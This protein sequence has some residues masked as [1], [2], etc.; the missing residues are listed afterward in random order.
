[1]NKPIGQDISY[2]QDG[3]YIFKA[4]TYVYKMK[5]GELPVDGYSEFYLGLFLATFDSSGLSIYDFCNNYRLV[6]HSDIIA[7]LRELGYD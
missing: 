4:P 3:T 7:K 6:L 1:M 2:E 5:K